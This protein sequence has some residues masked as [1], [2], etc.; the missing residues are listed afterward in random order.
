M[1]YHFTDTS[2]Y[3][4]ITNFLITINNR[5]LIQLTLVNLSLTFD[6]INIKIP[7]SIDIGYLIFIWS[8]SPKFYSLIH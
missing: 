1:K 7:I 5:K 4:V 6:V 8:S 3:N 2:V